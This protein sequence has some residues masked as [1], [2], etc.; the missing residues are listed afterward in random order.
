Y[1]YDYDIAD[2]ALTGRYVTK[3]TGAGTTNDVSRD[4]FYVCDLTKKLYCTVEEVWNRAGVDSNVATRD[5]VIPLIKESM[6]EIDAMMGKSFQYAT[7]VTQWF[8][9]NRDD[10]EIK[11]TSIYLN[12]KPIIDITSMKEYDVNSNLITTHEAADYWI[13]KNTGRITLL[14]KQFTK[15]VHRVEVIYTYGAIEVPQNISSLCAV[16]S[17]MRLLVHQIGMQY[18]DVTSWSAAGLSIGVGE[19]YTSMARA[20]EF[21]TKESTRLIASIGR[22]KPSCFIL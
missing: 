7:S 10:D 3:W 11:V 2:D 19:P 21:L 14:S 17:A 20:L 18:D 15:Q 1:Y 13:N 4:Q 9:T 16:L 12:Y 5:E 22:L 8:D 6:G